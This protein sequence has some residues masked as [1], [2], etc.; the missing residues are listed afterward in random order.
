MKNKPFPGD[1]YV[2]S[3]EK[4]KGPMITTNSTA[5]LIAGKKIYLY[6]HRQLSLNTIQEY[7]EELQTSAKVGTRY[8]YISHRSVFDTVSQID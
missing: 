3:S 8:R 6:I 7:S 5:I 4:S 1:A 2:D